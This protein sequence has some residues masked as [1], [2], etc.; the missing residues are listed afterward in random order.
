M[1]ENPQSYTFALKTLSTTHYKYLIHDLLFIKLYKETILDS[2]E[3]HKLNIDRTN[4]LM[5]VKLPLF[6]SIQELTKRRHEY[7]EYIRET[8]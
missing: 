4:L 3:Q 8:S 6:S 2:V 7:A 5:Q 1:A